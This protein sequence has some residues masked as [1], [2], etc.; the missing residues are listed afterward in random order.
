MAAAMASASGSALCFT[1]ASTS[2]ALCFAPSPRRSI[3][4]GFVDKSLVNLDQRLRLSNLKTRASNATAV[5]KNGSA[6][7]SD[8]VPTPVVIIDQDSDPDATV[9]EVTFG[10]R[11]G[12]LLDTMNALKNLGLNV[13]K[14]NV[15]LDSSG[16]HNKFA[17]TKADSGRKV[18]D[19][20]LLEA[21]RLTVINN[22]LEFHPESSSQLAMGAA[23]GVLPPTEPIDVDIATHISI[24]DDGPDRSLLFIETA[25]RPGLLV[26][27]VKI[28]SDISV[29]VESGEF[30][31][32]GLLAKV[33]FHVSY[34]NKALIKPLQQVLTNS[35]RYFLRRPSTDESSF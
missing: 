7:D 27:L 8:K 32:E 21:I 14:A 2:R 10:D 17:I 1:D 31:T 12:A 22:L 20:E 11:L 19:P 33:K 26:E 6:A 3:T 15:Y 4:F 9:V 16:K 34:K 13:V 29:A 25:D 18:E 30:D 24:E 23:F 35:M 5:E 28:I